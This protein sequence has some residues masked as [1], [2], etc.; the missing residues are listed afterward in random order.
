MLVGI[1]FDNTIAGFDHAFLEAARERGLVPGIFTGTKKNLRDAV[2]AG[3]DGEAEWMRLQ[4]RVY[5]PHMADAELIEG[6]DRFVAHCRRRGIPVCIVSHKT[7]YGHFD[8]ERVNLRDASRAWLEAKGFFDPEGPGLAPEQVHFESTREEKIARIAA[9]GC[10]HFVDD[11]E[12]VFREPS[13]PGNVRRYLL[14]AGAGPLP[15]G[16]FRAFRRWHDIAHDIL[17]TDC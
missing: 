8:A 14:A 4:G 11:L 10:T 5:G 9:L 1:D 16:P 17:G 2:R 12:E 7:E 6:A 15:Q 3:P 13:F